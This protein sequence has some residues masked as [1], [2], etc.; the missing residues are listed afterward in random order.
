MKLKSKLLYPAA[1]LVIA[2]SL[3]ILTGS[4]G[5]GYLTDGAVQNGVTGGW[6]TP[7]DM[8]CIV[9]VRTDGTLDIADAVINSRECIYLN[10]GTM[11]GGTP[12]DLTTMTSSDQCTKAGSGGNDGTKHFF[13]TSICVDSSGNG[14]PLT[15]LDRTYSMCVAKGGTWKQTSATPPYPEAPGIFPT[16]D[17]AGA[18]VAYGRQFRG[19]D[20][21]GAAL[22]FGTKGT[23]AADAGFCYAPMNMTTAYPTETACPVDRNGTPKAGFDSSTGYDYSWP[24]TGSTANKC[25][26]AK[27]IKGYPSSSL[28][29]ANGSTISTSTWVDLSAFTTMGQCIASG[30]SWNNWVGQPASTTSVATTPKA[31]TIPAWDFSRQAP[32]TTQGCLHCH[33]TVTQYNGPAERFK[34]SYLKHGHKNMLRKVTP[35]K[36]WA[37]PNEHG[38][39]EVYTSASTGPIDFSAA[40][41]FIAGVWRDLLYIFGDWMTPAPEGLNVIVNMNGSAKANGTSSQLCASCHTTGWSNSTAGLCSLSSK[42]TSA[43]CAA[44]GG[45][46]YPSI[47]VEGIGTPGFTPAEPAASF[48]AIDFTGGG[49]WDRDGIQCPRCHN[50]TAPKV[51]STQIAASAFP[52]T[53]ATA[54][55][56]GAL[57]SGTGITNLCFGCHQSIAKTDDGTGEDADLNHPENL[58]VTNTATAPNYVP[59]FYGRGP[60]NMFLN[61]PHARFTGKI[62]PNALGKYD[63]EDTTGNDNGNASKYSSLFQGYTCWQSATSSSPAK[64]MIVDGNVKEIKTKTD[65]ETLYGAGAWRTDT[66]GT[67]ATCH[68][69][70]NSLFVEEQKEAALRKVCTSCHNKSLAKMNHPDGAGTALNW[71]SEPSEACVTCHMPKAT[72]SGLR[73]H[74][75]RINTNTDYATFPT[76]TE[77]GVGATA[78]KKIANAAPDGTYTNAVWVDVDYVCG[79]CH[80]GSFGPTATKN[81]AVY[82]DKASLSEW[83]K[84]M[85]INA[86]PNV[87]FTTD[88][89]HYTVTLTDTST[90][91]SFFPDNAVTVKW[92]DGT[93]ST[94]DAGSV[95]SHTYPTT[96]NFKIVYSVRDSDGLVSEK[97][98]TVAAAFSITAN[99]SPPTPSDA[100]FT[101]L[102][103]NGK[104]IIRTGTGTSSF[105]FS[106]LKPG[107]Y[108]VK[109]QHLHCTFDGDG[110]RNANQNPAAVVIGTSDKTVTFAHTHTP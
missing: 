101:L 9:G 32:E 72:S 22:P 64:T 73:M 44:A 75:W 109:V 52:S 80:G 110:V 36:N 82:M 85:H 16:P 43:S 27:G 107:T 41:A 6:I 49:N 39:L 21:N 3:I 68:D 19:Q 29:K 70:H 78:S 60:G 25:I 84:N 103:K 14:I 18:C 108:K 100:T 57:A 50:V 88:I 67:C 61:S 12:F 11:N 34:D 74:L 8:V 54:G 102:G 5:A 17:F 104:S 53:H 96:A 26:Y 15:D 97:K 42:T 65:C 56:M 90:D 37:G 79:Q 105:V 23:S 20:A 63:L 1:F 66:Q 46:W 28:T 98:I 93:S 76:A 10:K 47:G 13:A 69:V 35:G 81:E 87:S 99:I 95:F 62:V 94:G 55:G 38:E 86:R 58:Q 2:S 83:A 71:V 4:A 7:N 89:D 91:D 40:T 106:G 45:T 77:F 92:G 48:P 51:V 30:G 31:S 33:S 59:D 24:T